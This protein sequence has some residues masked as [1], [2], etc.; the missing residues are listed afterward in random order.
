MAL[1]YVVVF[2]GLV[3]LA[4]QMLSMPLVWLVPPL[5]MLSQTLCRVDSSNVN[6][7]AKTK[8]FGTCWDPRG[9]DLL[10]NVRDNGGVEDEASQ[11][12]E[13]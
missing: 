12:C 10:S 5:R 11:L 4:M 6:E 7:I 9:K 13:V 1:S 3:E 2:G 8:E